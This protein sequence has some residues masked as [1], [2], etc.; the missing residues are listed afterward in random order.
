MADL[1]P[2]G[3]M[4]GQLNTSKE[5]SARLNAV[6][7]LVS[8]LRVSGL[9]NTGVYYDT[10]EHWDL[11]PSLIGERGAIYIYSNRSYID[12]GNGNLTPVPSI[13]IGDGMAYLIDMPFVN[14]DLLAIVSAHVADGSV[15]IT[16]AER[17]FWNNKVSSF[18]DSQD[19]ETLI[20][21]KTTF[22]ED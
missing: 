8:S 20:L 21:S 16:Q 7:S 11:Q 14:D 6:N 4:S 9:G 2:I 15:H 13:K 1:S 22:M 18:M 17:L 12:D 3:S 10:K 19:A 5:L